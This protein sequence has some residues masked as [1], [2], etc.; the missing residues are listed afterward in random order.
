MEAHAEFCTA[1]EIAKRLVTVTISCGCHQL[2]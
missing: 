2:I 1:E